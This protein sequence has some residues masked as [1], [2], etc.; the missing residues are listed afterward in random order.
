MQQKAARL[1]KRTQI[2]EYELRIVPF[3]FTALW[4]RFILWI[5]QCLCL[6]QDPKLTEKLVM[7]NYRN[8]LQPSTIRMNNANSPVSAHTLASYFY[9]CYKTTQSTAKT[10]KE[11]SKHLEGEGYLTLLSKQKVKSKVKQ[12]TGAIETMIQTI[13]DANTAQS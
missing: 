1:P 10:V 3:V 5:F 6:C 4:G 7:G 9:A 8:L 13:L 12:D 11:F 2:D